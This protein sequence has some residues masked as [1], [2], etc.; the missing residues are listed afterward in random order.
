M[1]IFGQIIFVQVTSPGPVIE[2]NNFQLC[3][4]NNLLSYLVLLATE[5]KI[6]KTL[7]NSFNNK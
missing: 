2:R 4:C 3:Q 6:L 7:Q 5:S 1:Q